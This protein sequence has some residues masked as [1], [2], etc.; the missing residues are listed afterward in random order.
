MHQNYSIVAQ[1]YSNLYAILANDSNERLF[2]LIVSMLSI[3][4]GTPLLYFVI[5]FEK[6]G[7][8]R[9]RTL[10][11]MF[12]SMNCWTSIGMSLLVQTSVIFR[13]LYGQLPML[14]CN[15]QSVLKY[16]VVCS[17]VLNTSATVLT[18]HAYIFWLK[19]PAAFHDSFWYQFLFLWNYT[20]S[21]IFIR[22]LHMIGS[23]KIKGIYFCNATRPSNDLDVSPMKGLAFL[24]TIS[25]IINLIIKL[26]IF[27]Y[28]KVKYFFV[29]CSI[30][31]KMILKDI[32]RTFAI[33][34]MKHFLE[35]CYISYKKILTK[36]FT[37]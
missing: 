8:G 12:I 10:I 35:F 36:L 23:F 33:I 31:L 1:N 34:F 3:V 27:L 29:I 5:W 32:W 37:V 30:R 26:K 13:Y 9:K 24:V 11:N 19:N 20:I 15:I 6:Y 16:S 25:G 17:L 2:C 7:S 28:N 18:Q 14:V 22:S 21:L 4:L